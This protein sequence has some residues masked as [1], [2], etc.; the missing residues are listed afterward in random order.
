MG[1]RQTTPTHHRLHWTSLAQCEDGFPQQARTPYQTI[2][3]KGK[4]SASKVEVERRMDMCQHIIMVSNL[5]LFFS[6]Q[7]LGE[8][9]Q[10]HYRGRQ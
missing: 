3:T 4:E 7:S 5:I 6:L 10:G 1:H 9:P 2:R 8:T